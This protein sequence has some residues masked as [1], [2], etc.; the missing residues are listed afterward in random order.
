MMSI[1]APPLT[2]A[3]IGEAA[4][5]GSD[6]TKVCTAEFDHTFALSETLVNDS[7][8]RP[9]RDLRNE[10]DCRVPPTQARH[11]AHGG[12]DERRGFVTSQRGGCDA[13]EAQLRSKDRLFL[14]LIV[15]NAI[16]AG[17]HDPALRSRLTE[18]DDVLRGLRKQLV[19]HAD[20][21]P[22][23]T[24]SLRHFLSAERSIDEEYEGL[25]RLSPAGARSGPLLRC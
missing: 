12:Q 8:F 24:K 18:P 4:G 25:R 20:V 11:G 13:E 6:G 1:C 10:S 9:A 21:E 23:G 2:V 15:T 22:S 7:H 16:V 17:D 19:M 5:S 14:K 3:L